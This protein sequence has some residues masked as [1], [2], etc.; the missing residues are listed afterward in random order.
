MKF[1]TTSKKFPADAKSWAA[2]VAAAP[3]KNRKPTTKEAAQWSEAAVVKGGGYQAVR[4]A[5]AAK[6]KPGERGPQL[7]PTKQLV[8]IRYSAEVLEFFKR[9]GTGWQT[10][11]D[12]TLKKWVA[13]QKR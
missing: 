7:S 6:R 9:G 5:V 4:K 12:D 11:M 3:G 2:V 13:R 10:R 1:K 8:S